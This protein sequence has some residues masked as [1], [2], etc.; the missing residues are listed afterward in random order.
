MNPHK[1][2]SR[3]RI[4]HVLHTPRVRINDAR[5]VDEMAGFRLAG[6]A[7]SSPLSDHAALTFAAE[8]N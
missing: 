1:D 4:D 8:I 5:Y 6:P 3:S 7:S 2:T